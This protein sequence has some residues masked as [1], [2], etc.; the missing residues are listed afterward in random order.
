MI[1]ASLIIF[2]IHATTRVRMIF[3]PL[4][5]KVSELFEFLLY[6]KLGEYERTTKVAFIL[7]PL[8]DCPACM[9]SVW[10]TVY[11]FTIGSSL[12]YLVFIFALSG[13]NWLIT[14]YMPE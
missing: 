12:P 5:K 2:G 8:F 1:L 9:A 11:Y 4:R 3:H 6:R 7:K 14:M 10:G 13:L